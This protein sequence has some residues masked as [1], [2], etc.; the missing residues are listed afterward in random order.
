M[1]QIEQA[2]K[3]QQS[4]PTIKVGDLVYLS[5]KDLNLP[6]GRVRKLQPNYIGPYAV[7]EVWPDTSNYRVELLPELNK[8]GIRN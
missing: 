6:K 3:L 4:E 7:I 1:S 2:N 8:C 5:M